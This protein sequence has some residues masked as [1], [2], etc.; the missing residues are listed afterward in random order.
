MPMKKTKKVRLELFDTW[1]S[2]FATLK[3]VNNSGLRGEKLEEFVVI[4]EGP[5]RLL[6]L[7]YQLPNPKKKR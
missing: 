3:S 6:Y 5:I 1:R 2:I 4:N 7:N